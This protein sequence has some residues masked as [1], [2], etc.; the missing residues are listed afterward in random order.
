MALTPLDVNF[1]AQRALRFG[2]RDRDKRAATWKLW[3][4]TARG[5]SDVY[6]ACRA[7]GGSLKASLHQ[8]GNWHIAYSREAFEQLVIGSVP[9]A[10]NRFI[11]KW[12]RPSEIATGVTL[13]FR[14]V[15]PWS[16]VTSMIDNSD[17]S[18]IT[19]LPNAPRQKATEVDILFVNA[20]V[21][22]TDWPGKRSMGTS[23]VGSIALENGYRVWAVSWVIEM[24]DLSR[25][26]KG[27]GGFY[28]GRSRADLKDAQMRALVF[29]NETDGSRVL[30]D[31]PVQGP[32]S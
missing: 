21:P 30:Y 2:I 28:K 27:S 20:A 24:P 18:A 6:L 10:T 19:W 9:N 7:L 4:E 3:T 11:D 8:S 13:A 15:T 32:N 14:I 16:A 22:V 23:L 25:L 12:P 29:G 5:N 26:N 31:C 1:M 17:D